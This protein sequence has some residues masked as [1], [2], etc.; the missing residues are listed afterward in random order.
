MIRKKGS[1]LELTFAGKVGSVREILAGKTM[2]QH[3]GFMEMDPSSIGLSWLLGMLNDEQRK[4]RILS[5]T[6]ADLG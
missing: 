6:H 1:K 3:H 5:A 2:D 4:Q